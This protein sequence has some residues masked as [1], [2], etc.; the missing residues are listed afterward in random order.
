MKRLAM[1]L[2]VLTIFLSMILPAQAAIMNSPS[3]SGIQIFPKDHIF[4]TRV[5]NLPVDAKSDVYINDLKKDT[6]STLNHYINNAI[7]YNVV[8]ST[9][10]HQYITS[11][12]Y[13]PYSDKVHILYPT[14][15]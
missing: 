7:P 15:H 12:L 4:N 14:I 13:A 2:L 5:D 3:L 9:Q 8:D 1:L 6:G 10:R 11:F